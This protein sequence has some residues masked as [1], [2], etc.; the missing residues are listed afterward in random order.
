MRL[1]LESIISD[2][3]HKRSKSQNYD[4]C[5]REP[6][7]ANMISSRSRVRDALGGR[8][9]LGFA[10]DHRA[11]V[12]LLSDPLLERRLRRQ[13]ARYLPRCMSAG[14]VLQMGRN[15]ERPD[16]PRG[17]HLRIHRRNGRRN[18][19][20]LAREAALAQEPKRNR[21][22][23]LS[24]VPPSYSVAAVNNGPRADIM[25]RHACQIPKIH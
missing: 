10:A 19:G 4:R 24:H 25:T 11:P 22:Y 5:T 6:T 12:P 20:R 2:A 23:Y 13:P 17:L 1:V 21:E 9:D 18:L 14:A 7:G 8:R 15:V 3:G 16:Q